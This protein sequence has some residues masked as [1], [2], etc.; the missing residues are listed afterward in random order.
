D[1]PV[2]HL[3]FHKPGVI[4]RG[5]DLQLAHCCNELGIHKSQSDFERDLDS[6]N[7]TIIRVGYARFGSLTAKKE[8]CLSVEVELLRRLRMFDLNLPC[9]APLNPFLLEKSHLWFRLKEAGQRWFKSCFALGGTSGFRWS[10]GAVQIRIDLP[11]HPPVTAIQCNDLVL[12][13][14]RTESQIWTLEVILECSVPVLS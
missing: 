5:V 8:K 13:N 7:I 4:D 11:G 2:L 10:F 14:V 12:T 3:R 9:H 6:A 1:Y